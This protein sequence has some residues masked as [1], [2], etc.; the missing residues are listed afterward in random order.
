L[1]LSPMTR[2]FVRFRRTYLRCGRLELFFLIFFTFPFECRTTIGL[3]LYRLVSITLT[4]H[5]PP[6]FAVF[7]GPFINS[8]PPSDFV[9]FPIFKNFEPP[10]DFEIFLKFLKIPDHHF[11]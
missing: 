1:R 10:P 11:F 4:S 5:Q 7:S 9:V 2:R 6:D 8:A 3:V